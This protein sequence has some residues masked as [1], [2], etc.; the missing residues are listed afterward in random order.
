MGGRLAALDCSCRDEACELANPV[1][2][3]A[4]ASLPDEH[5]VLGLCTLQMPGQEERDGVA[6]SVGNIMQA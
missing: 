1:C 6:A 2:A 5:L 4:G 3:L